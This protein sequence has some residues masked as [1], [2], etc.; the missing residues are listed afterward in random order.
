MPEADIPQCLFGPFG[1]D[2]P[3]SLPSEAVP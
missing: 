2:S 3:P 1:M